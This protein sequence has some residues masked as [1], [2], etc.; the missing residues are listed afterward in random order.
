[1]KQLEHVM[2][3]VLENLNERLE[4]NLSESEIENYDYSLSIF[5]TSVENGLGIDS[6]EGLEIILMLK[7]VYGVEFVEDDMNR[8]QSVESI[9]LLINERGEKK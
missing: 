2:K 1:M 6:V 5:S 9:A 8:L 4:L 3:D 7:Q